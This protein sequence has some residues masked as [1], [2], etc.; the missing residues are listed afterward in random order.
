VKRSSKDPVPSITY[1]GMDKLGKS[2]LSGK[3][4]A[5]LMIGFEDGDGD[6]FVDDAAQGPTVV[7]I[8]FFLDQATQT[9][10]VQ[11]DPI[12]NDTL[13]VTNSIRQPDNGYYKGRAIK[14]TIYIP[15]TEFRPNDS[16]RAVKFR[17]FVEDVKGH[18]SNVIT[19]PPL[20]V[21][22]N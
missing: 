13:R 20:T 21:P 15:F 10:S 19:T 2:A 3:D 6:L 18:K 5:V 1:E 12:T 14:G 8:P 11:W 22:M 17:G 4:T 16:I 9:Y 7:F